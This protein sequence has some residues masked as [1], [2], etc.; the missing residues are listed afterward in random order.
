MY[1]PG[2]TSTLPHLVL[3]GNAGSVRECRCVDEGKLNR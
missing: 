3:W 2:D 1:I